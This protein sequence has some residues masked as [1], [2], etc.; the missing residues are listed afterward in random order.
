MAPAT[1]TRSSRAKKAEENAP[2]NGTTSSNSDGSVAA[3]DLSRWRLRTSG[4]SHGRHTWHYL[5]D[6]PKVLAD[7]P[8]SL[9]DKYWLG[10]PFSEKEAGALPRPTNPLDAAR[11]GFSFYKKIQ[12]SDGHWAGEYGGPMFLL[13]GLVI[14]MYVTKTP[15]PDEWKIEMTRYLVNRA[16]KV[17]GGWGIHIESPSTVFGTALNYAAIRLLGMSADHP[18]AV[19]ARTTLHKL[20]GAV[21]AP[22]WGKLWL[23]ILNCY[24]WSGMNPIPPELWCLPDWVPIHPWRWWIHTRQ[25]YIPMGYLWGKRFAAE[26]DPTIESL[27]QELYVQ[28]YETIDWPA[29]RNNVA[30]GDVYSPHTYTLEALM[31]LLGKY[32][33]RHIKMLRSAGIKRAYKLLCLEDENTSYQCIGPVNKMLNYVCRWIEEGADSEVMRQHRAKIDDF[34]WMCS[35]GAMMTGTNGSQLW[36]AAFI[37][38]AVVESE[39]AEEP[40][41][42]ESCQRLLDWIADCQIRENPKHY[43]SGY[44]FATKGAWPFST[45]EQGYVVSDCTGEGLKAVL[46]L[47]SLGSL[48]ERVSLE[49]VQ[50][51]V[52]LLLTMQNKDGGFASYETINGPALLEW[53]NPAEV[54]GDIMVRAKRDRGF[55]VSTPSLEDG[56]LRSSFALTDRIQLRRMHHIRRHRPAQGAADLRVSRR[57]HR[58]VHCGC[59]AVDPAQAAR[60]RELAR[61]VGDLLHVRGHV[62]ARE[63]E[64]R[65]PHLR[66]HARGAARLPLPPL[67]AARRRRMGRDVHVLRHG[68]VRPCGREPG[69][70]D[71]FRPDC[72][73]ARRLPREGPGADPQGGTAHH[74]EAA[75]RW[76][77]E[78][79]AHRRRLQQEL[80]VL[81]EIFSFI[82][83][84]LKNDLG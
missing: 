16:H 64:A 25:V 50:D 9:E 27:R 24:D 4:G 26:L 20:G 31:A 56:P 28:P 12:S 80:W 74:E 66:Q 33:Q 38:Q 6:D 13:P 77:V 23:A 32:E 81:L 37:A 22:S 72:A 43:K 35:E 42:A 52:D 65:R 70:P 21:G 78:A 39:I 49:R 63:P 30:K 14:G 83:W 41:H 34:V 5:P 69:G 73:H 18:V 51:S 8:Q 44:R 40:E 7:W 62:R 11:N 55:V 71:R 2:A 54:F 79:G 58:P 67:Q 1:S 17:D 53:I 3:T 59:C 36:D 48:E 47:Q 10:I 15:I 45:P 29:Q 75:T 57:G 19:K 76:P 46:M 84:C 61:L 68:R 82:T 60:G